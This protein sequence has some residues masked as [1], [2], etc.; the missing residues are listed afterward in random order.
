M[1]YIIDYYIP[2]NMELMITYAFVVV[3]VV[4]VVVRH[5]LLVW[6]LTSC[7]IW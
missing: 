2:Y 4:V 5:S 7:W 3:V 1:V 6:V